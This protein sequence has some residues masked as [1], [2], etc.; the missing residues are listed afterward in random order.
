MNECRTAA[1]SCGSF[2]AWL[3]FFFHK[4]GKQHKHECEY[5]LV[6]VL[7]HVIVRSN[8]RKQQ[9]YST[10][11][12]ND[13]ESSNNLQLCVRSPDEQ[14]KKNIRV[15]LQNETCNFENAQTKTLHWIDATKDDTTREIEREKQG[16]R[17]SAISYRCC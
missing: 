1:F 7:M 6:F 8:E 3:Y 15:Y 9:Q 14:E 5:V 4:N 13:I 10:L 17:E 12:Y 11:K 16:E 2:N